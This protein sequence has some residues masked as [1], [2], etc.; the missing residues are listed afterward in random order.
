MDARVDR[1]PTRR[2]MLYIATGTFGALGAAAAIWPFLSQMSPD[3]STRAL[4]AVEI[5]LASLPAGGIITVKWRGKPVFVRHR[6]LGEIQAAANVRM[7]DLL[8]PHT[9]SARVQRP[10]WLV[11]IGVCPHLGCVPLGDPGRR[12]EFDGWFCPCHGSQF[13]TSGRVRRGPAPTNLVVPPYTFVSETR[14]RIG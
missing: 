11:V 4:G 9:D 3:A 10:E 12:G 2:D 1:G 5:D 13:D 7:A 14:I 6:T 8:D